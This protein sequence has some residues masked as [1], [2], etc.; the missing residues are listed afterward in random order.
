MS[1]SLAAAT[2][3]CC[4]TYRKQQEEKTTGSETR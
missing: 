2:A 1:G 4:G 3:V